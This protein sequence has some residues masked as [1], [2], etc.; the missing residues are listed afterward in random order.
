MFYYSLD[1]LMFFDRVRLFPATYI[2]LLVQ[3]SS[4]TRLNFSW[5][6]PE[7]LAGC[8]GP[9]NDVELLFLRKQGISLI[10]RLVEKRKARISKEQ[11]TRVGLKDLHEPIIDFRAPSQEQI[12]KI[13]TEVKDVLSKGG[14][15]AVSCGA[16]IGR[17]GTILSCILISFC[18]TLDKAIEK[19]RE[20]RRQEQAW[21]TM[22]QHQ[23]IVRFAESMEKNIPLAS[24]KRCMVAEIK[25]PLECSRKEIE[26]LFQLVQ[27]GGEVD[28]SGLKTRIKRAKYLAFQFDQNKLVGILGLKRP[29]E[30][31]KK[32]VFKKAGLPKDAEKFDLEIGWAYTECLYRGRGICTNLIQLIL[33][34][35]GN[36]NLF[37]TVRTENAAMCR[38]LEKTGFEKIG[39]PY[40]GRSK[41]YTLQ[42]FAR[43]KES[44]LA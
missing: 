33:S 38:V 8:A 25:K 43:F 36:E 31:Y 39:I 29:C 37:A 17:T 24:E 12:N 32:R 4:M 20:T 3:G 34:K 30:I 21:E 15:V 18:Y 1:T 11:L 7:K 44:M 9:I 22:D 16:G 26:G 14:R 28:P 40:K 10:V 42:L 6:I 23:A 19:V 13:V 2:V 5:V 27:K 35:S 41:G